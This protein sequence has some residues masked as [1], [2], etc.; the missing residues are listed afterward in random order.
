MLFDVYVLSQRTKNKLPLRN[1]CMRYS[2]SLMVDGLILIQQDVEVNISRTLVDQLLA[3]HR[4]FYIL[5]LV[6]Q[7]QRL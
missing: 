5:Q 1:T 7:F 6:Q 4:D 2:Q 3:A